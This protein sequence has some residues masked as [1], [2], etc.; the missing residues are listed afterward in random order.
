MEQRNIAFFEEEQKLSHPTEN[1]R[2][3]FKIPTP[4]GKKLLFF[5]FRVFPYS[6]TTTHHCRGSKQQL[7][8]ACCGT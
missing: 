3:H 1:Y 4:G 2:K 8:S 5:P 7:D 6:S